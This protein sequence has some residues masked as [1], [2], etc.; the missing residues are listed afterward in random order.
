MSKRLDNSPWPPPFRVGILGAGFV[1]LLAAAFLKKQGIPFFL[2]EKAPSPSVQSAPDARAFALSL[3]SL[4]ILKAV[5]LL[6]LI[7]ANSRVLKSIK[8]IKSKQE[9][10]SCEPCLVGDTHFGAIIA[11]SLLHH[12]LRDAIG[13][14]AILYGSEV[15][16]I[17]SI[18]AINGQFKKWQIETTQKEITYF[19]DLLLINDGNPSKGAELLGL[20]PWIE[21]KIYQAELCNLVLNQPLEDAAYQFMIDEDDAMALLPAPSPMKSQAKCIRVHRKPDKASAIQSDPLLTINRQL[22]CIGLQ[23][24][25]Q[26]FTL[27]KIP[28]LQF[29]RLLSPAIPQA[30]F[31]GNAANALLPVGAQ[32]LNLGFRDVKAFIE[33]YQQKGLDVGRYYAAARQK[34]HDTSRNFIDQILQNTNTADFFCADNLQFIQK[35]T[36]W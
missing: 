30:L 22:A 14:D 5:D 27:Q 32:G 33:L 28:A 8:V 3:S 17:H 34:D 25:A 7:L 18:D 1:G 4:E 19:A 2:L 15:T 10:L 31:L 16:A 20:Q 36:G 26:P 9:I 24:K 23:A 6:P 13:Q 21:P 12:I 35:G 29:S 11:A